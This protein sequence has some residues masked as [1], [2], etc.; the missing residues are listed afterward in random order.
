MSHF[1]KLAKLTTL[2]ILKKLLATH[3]VNMLAS[4]AVLNETF[5][6]NF[7]HRVCATILLLHHLLAS[8]AA[9]RDVHPLSL[10]YRVVQEKNIAFLRFP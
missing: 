1:Q 5:L 9:T 4:L 10:C 3:N 8:S 2:S 6:C 7:K